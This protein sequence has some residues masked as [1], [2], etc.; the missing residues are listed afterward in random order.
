MWT[1]EEQAQRQ[2]Q[3]MMQNPTREGKKNE[4]TCIRLF[5]PAPS[6]PVC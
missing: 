3:Q 2:L 6:A 4:Y 5:A 1:T